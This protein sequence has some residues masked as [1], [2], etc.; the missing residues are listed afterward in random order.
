MHKFTSIILLV[1]TTLFTGCEQQ[2]EQTLKVGISPW[3]GYEPLALAS[4]K[5]FY[6]N[7]QVRIIRFGTPTESYRAL[8]DG[9]IDVAAFTADEVIHYAESR[10]KPRIF[11]VLDISNGAD[12]IV[13]NKDIKTLDDLKGKR[14]GVEGSALGDYVMH[15]AMDFTKNLK[16]TDMTLKNVEISQQEQAF[17]NG[18]IDAA[19]TYEPS[20]SLLINAGAHVVFDSSQIPYEIVDV[21]VTNDK[22][23]QTKAQRLKNLAEGWYK[24]QDFINGH[25]K[26]SMNLMSKNESTTIEEF[27]KGYE[28]LI[29]PNKA[30]NLD[31]L[32]KDG[33]LVKPLQRLSKLMYS[34]GSLSKEIDVKPLLDRRIIESLK[35]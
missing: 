22:T 23:I 1:I 7:T 13:A 11:L 4:E 5:N 21:L 8:R 26:E 34:K 19:I 15:R 16:T 33:S 10:H 14:L 28:D 25:Y 27:Q 3:P 29:L 12:A 18:E 31:M 35:D 24:A 2:I 20:K 6:Q 30:D 17:I 9:I 32:G